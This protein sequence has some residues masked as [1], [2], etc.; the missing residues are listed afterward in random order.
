MALYDGEKT[1][2][3]V[4]FLDGSVDAKYNDNL[5]FSLV[6]HNGI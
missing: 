2:K 5:C 6:M 3:K 1:L 4:L